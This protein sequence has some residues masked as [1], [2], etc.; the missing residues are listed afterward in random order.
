M[1]HISQQHSLSLEKK[2]RK[3]EHTVAANLGNLL[4]TCSIHPLPFLWAFHLQASV[5]TKTPQ[6]ECLQN[7]S[8]LVS[9]A[10]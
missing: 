1:K 10:F 8:I 4:Q 9:R 6:I 2:N 3:Q 7:T 5:T